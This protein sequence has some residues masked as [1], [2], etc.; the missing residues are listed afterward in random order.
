MTIKS[1]STAAILALG[2]VVAAVPGEA[3]QQQMGAHQGMG[4]GR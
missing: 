1:A 3:S 4:P 2:L